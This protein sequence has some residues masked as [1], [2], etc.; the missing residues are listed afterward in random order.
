M[1]HNCLINSK[2]LKE[3]SPYPLN[4]NTKELD[5]YIKLAE[6]QYILPLI[7]NDFY[8][9]LLEQV[10]NNELTQENSTA[11][12]EAIY[13]LLGFAVCYEAL[14]ATWAS[15]TEIGVVKGHSD[16]SE[17]LTLKDLTLV[18][19]HLK[20]QVQIRIDYAKHWLCEHQNYYPNLD[21]CEC[22]CSNCNKGK[23]ALK[24]TAPNLELYSTRRKNTTLK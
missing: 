3:F 8:D 18:Q 9:E 13:P 4:Y 15:V 2:W 20:N 10:E 16:N 5:N 11:L 24:N 22:G 6:V 14:P 19:Q 12:I 23:N 1:I 7:G 17:S 21:I